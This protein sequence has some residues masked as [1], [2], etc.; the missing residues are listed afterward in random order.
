MTLY[1]NIDHTVVELKFSAG[2][3]FKFIS[4]E[5]FVL[6]QTNITQ[7]ERHYSFMWTHVNLSNVTINEREKAKGNKKKK[8]YL[9]KN[10]VNESEFMKFF[11]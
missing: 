10:M 5:I 3:L 7:Y 8:D 9:F 1:N 4:Q 6:K 11:F 2:H